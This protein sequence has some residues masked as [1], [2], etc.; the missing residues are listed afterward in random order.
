MFGRV[1]GMAGEQRDI[2][3][4]KRRRRIRKLINLNLKVRRRQDLKI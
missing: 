2:E 1:A 3:N 4:G